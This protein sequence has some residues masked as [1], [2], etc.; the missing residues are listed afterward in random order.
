MKTT[1]FLVRHGV[2]ENPK[3]ILYGRN[4]DLELNDK[5]KKEILDLANKIKALGFRLDKTYSSPLKRTIESAKIFDKVFG[6]GNEVVE[7]LTDTDIPVTF[8]S[9]RYKRKFTY[10][11]EYIEKGNESPQHIIDRMNRAFRKILSAN[12]GKT[13]AI[14]GHG[15]PLRFLLYSLSHP[16]ENNPS[17]PSLQHSKYI[18]K[19]TAVKLILENGV[20]LERE[21]IKPQNYRSSSIINL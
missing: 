13:V 1:V 19:G 9:P 17:L 14:I 12:E 8:G 16:K 10:R 20:L 2:V 21:F 4:M 11:A 6:I 15:D 18:F 7:D 5:G 3:D